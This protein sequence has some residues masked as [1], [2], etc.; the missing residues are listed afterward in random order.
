MIWSIFQQQMPVFLWIN[1]FVYYRSIF[2]A[3]VKW[4]VNFFLWLFGMRKRKRN[5]L[6]F[7]LQ[8]H[9]R[10]NEAHYLNTVYFSC[11]H[12]NPICF[13]ICFCFMISARCA[14]PFQLAD[15]IEGIVKID[16]YVG[17]RDPMKRELNLLLSK[18][19]FYW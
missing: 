6:N 4:K 8:T 16:L 11:F 2:I 10:Q 14:S 5:G 9:S 3:L 13:S 18:P 19:I 1:T 17:P 7:G 15:L 12:W